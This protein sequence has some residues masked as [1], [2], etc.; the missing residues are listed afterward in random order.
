MNR[1][2]STITLLVATAVLIL[3][4]PVPLFAADPL[5]YY[6]DINCTGGVPDVAKPTLEIYPG[7]SVI[8]RINTTTC[9]TV[10]ISGIPPIGNFTLRKTNSTNTV[11][12]PNSGTFTYTVTDSVSNSTKTGCS[13]IVSGQV[14]SLS[15]LGMIILI[16]LI[17][18]TGVYL[19]I[20]RKPVTT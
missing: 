8:F 16:A 17:I 6:L 3:I 20:R 18:V 9:D 13:I 5:Y 10:F 19:W 11:I 7:A 15:S 12:F 4:Y 2:K 1:F 14:P